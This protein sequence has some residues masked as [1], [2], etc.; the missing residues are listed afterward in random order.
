MKTSQK[1]SFE[2][3]PSDRRKRWQT[4]FRFGVGAWNR[5][6]GHIRLHKHN[7]YIDNRMQPR[8]DDYN[9]VLSPYIE[10]MKNNL[11]HY[12]W[13][14]GIVVLS[15]VSIRVGEGYIPCAVLVPPDTYVLCRV[16]IPEIDAYVTR[17]RRTTPTP[18]YDK[19]VDPMMASAP[20]FRADHG[21]FM[22]VEDDAPI[23]GCGADDID[24]L[25]ADAVRGVTRD[26]NL[27]IIEPDASGLPFG[28]RTNSAVEQYLPIYEYYLSMVSENARNVA[29]ASNKT[30]WAEFDPR[31]CEQQPVGGTDPASVSE[32][33]SPSYVANAWSGINAQHES[34]AIAAAAMVEGRIMEEVDDANHARFGTGMPVHTDADGNIL[35]RPSAREGAIWRE[36]ARHG[37]GPLP[38]GW[39]ISAASVTA[40]RFDPI[41]CTAALEAAR[42]ARN[43]AYG[44]S[45]NSDF[46]S[47][48][49][50]AG[51]VLEQAVIASAINSAVTIVNEILTRVFN[52]FYRSPATRGS[53][54]A[55]ISNAYDTL[56][57]PEIKRRILSF[58]EANSG[59]E[60]ATR[61][62]SAYR[63]WSK[64]PYIGLQARARMMLG[65][66]NSGEGHDDDD[67]AES[68]PTTKKKKKKGDTTEEKRKKSRRS[69][70]DAGEKQHK[71]QQ[72]DDA[73]TAM[74]IIIEDRIRHLETASLEA[75]GRG[76]DN[77]DGEHKITLSEHLIE[78]LTN[79]GA[80][81]LQFFKEAGLA[82]HGWFGDVLRD[83]LDSSTKQFHLGIAQWAPTLTDEQL[84]TRAINGSITAE[85]FALAMR[86]QGGFSVT[87]VPKA[88]I[89]ASADYITMLRRR[90]LG[91]ETASGIV[92][93]TTPQA[94]HQQAEGVVPSKRAREGQ[95]VPTEG[96]ADNEEEE[97]KLAPKKKKKKKADSKS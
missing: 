50:N 2:E 97:E 81:D 87:H 3:T 14:D 31:R 66:E 44:F 62:A 43:A 15:V 83:A 45:E 95:L 75:G 34:A 30:L 38:A 61:V 23:M 4:H 73:T 92:Q 60:Q 22:A 67:D 59:T 24:G 11:M 20:H 42:R 85:E 26:D 8:T 69:A 64:N 39:S 40:S 79:R 94:M 10:T 82:T 55:V 21:V 18:A 63:K 80:A 46:S 96:D 47:T 17:V 70:A 86:K 74:S 88:I 29:R 72:E 68:E 28:A 51:V 89:S 32:I 57:V 33:P 54:F 56:M 76:V 77:G 25:L 16:F 9:R 27:V 12:V 53:S 78:M 71:E 90:M 93:E 65:K 91:S 36:L 7:V 5:I 52:L 37:I 13:C 6:Q 1:K 41:D 49:V 58:L 48:R 35:S 19:P 84:E